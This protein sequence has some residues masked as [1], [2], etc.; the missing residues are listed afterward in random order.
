MGAK[1]NIIAYPESLATIP[2]RRGAEGGRRIPEGVREHRPNRSGQDSRG[3]VARI[4]APPEE[5]A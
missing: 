2:G 5:V 4:I 3:Q 1:P